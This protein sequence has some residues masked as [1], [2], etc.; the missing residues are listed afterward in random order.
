MVICMSLGFAAPASAVPATPNDGGFHLQWNL[1]MIGAPEAW[2][3]ATGAG[4]TIA[5]VDSGVDLGHEDL[6]DQV[7]GHVTCVGSAGDVAKCVDG[8][9]D[10]NGHGTHVAGIAAAVTNNGRG[11]A[12]VAPDAKIL[13]VKVLQQSCDTI[14]GCDASGTPDDI[15]A[16]IKYA[17]DHGA[18]VINLSLGN[19]SQSVFGPAFQ[20]ALNYAF[21]KGAIPVIAAGNSYVLPSGGAV[22]A[23]V[24]GALN[25]HGNAASYSN[26]I[27]D[28]QWALMAPG[29]EADTE[30]G[31][32]SDPVGV[33]STYLTAYA[34]LAGTSMAAPHVS[35]AAAVLRSMGFSKQDT[36]ARLLS[37][38]KK[39]DPPA[40]YG[41]GSLD[42]AAAVG[43][44]ATT[45]P[46]PPSTSPN[47]TTLS[48]GSVASGSPGD[49]ASSSSSAPVPNGP[50]A[51]TPS[52]DLGG[53]TSTSPAGVINL[54]GQQAAPAPGGVVTRSPNTN[55]GLSPGL[56]A[57]A[58]VMAAGVGIGTGWFLR[59]GNL[60]RRT[61]P[62]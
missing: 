24:V 8:G 12:G 38:A 50:P 21:D 44:T 45:A 17:A 62:S 28:A 33:L 18:A 14:N 1:R 22:N 46:P 51:S 19:A 58:V 61:R 56:V 20:D 60:A 52:G 42:L 11:V 2:Q 9:Q 5:I 16:G 40:F 59:R 10:D 36:I 41:S 57:V 54:P 43:V 25:N 55:N 4:I 26:S 15:A 6:K 7:I 3:M 31:C 37:T 32:N 35:G 53:P 48:T 23:I 49:D 34:C 30:A 39:I 27:G 13:D 29:G 47:E